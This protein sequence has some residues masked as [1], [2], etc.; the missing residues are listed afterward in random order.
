MANFFSPTK[1]KW[2]QS[3]VIFA[4]LIL[5]S[6]LV[7]SVV[8]AYKRRS[9]STGVDAGDIQQIREK[10]QK[11]HESDLSLDNPKPHKKA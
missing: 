9:G 7:G 5:F 6:L 3:T 1:F 11:E 10:M 2:F 4:C 8:I